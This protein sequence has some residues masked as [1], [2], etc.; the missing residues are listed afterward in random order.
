MQWRLDHDARFFVLVP[1]PVITNQARCRQ[2]TRCSTR[3]QGL[4]NDQRVLTAHGGNAYY[5]R[6]LADW[7]EAP[8]SAFRQNPFRAIVSWEGA[9][10]VRQPARTRVVRSFPNLRMASIETGSDWVFTSSTS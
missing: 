5:S 9:G 10:L 3:C 6:Y 1:G 2:L 4:L 7:G 8:R